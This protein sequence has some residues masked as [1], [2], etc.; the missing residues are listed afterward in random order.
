MAAM[1]QFATFWLTAYNFND[2]GKLAIFFIGFRM[3]VT[4]VDSA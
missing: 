4:H 1:L 2:K 3:V